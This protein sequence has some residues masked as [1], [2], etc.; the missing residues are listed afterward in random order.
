MAEVVLFLSPHL[1]DAVLSCAGRIQAEV[2]DGHRVV[3]ATVF[4]A[5]GRTEASRRHYDRRRVEDRE[6]TQL[7]GAEP[8]WLDLPDAPFRRDYYRCYREICFET[9]PD[10]VG[11]ADEV[12]RYVHALCAE[13]NPVRLYA[14]LGVGTHI[15]HRLTLAAAQAQARPSSVT[16]YEDR[17]YALVRYAVRMRLMQLGQRDDTQDLPRDFEATPPDLLQ[18]S[19]I[20]SFDAAHWTH[21]YLPPGPER[22]ACKSRLVT[23]LL[24][25]RPETNCCYRCD[26]QT[27]DTNVFSRA[28]DAAATY[29]SQFPDLFRSRDDLIARTYDYSDLLGVGNALAERY[30]MKCD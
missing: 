17:P 13:V 22:D 21:T 12:A 14:P 3:V 5:G 20:A 2:R 28:I 4:S 30:W 27:Y 11:Y 10:D 9:H 23:H 19:L 29:C 7:L 15:D 6:A 8:L 1:D 24:H 18:T 26:I 25:D 16:Y